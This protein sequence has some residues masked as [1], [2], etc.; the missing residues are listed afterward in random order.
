MTKIKQ[1]RLVLLGGI[2]L[3][4]FCLNFLMV[5]IANADFKWFITSPKTKTVEDL[6][7]KIIDFI[8]TLSS[9]LGGVVVL[10][11]VIAGIRYVMAKG[12]EE[13]QAAKGALF[14]ALI[15]LF[16]I[17]TAWGIFYITVNIVRVLFGATAIK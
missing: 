5:G 15:G 14:N 11:I 1:N 12:P 9:V 13:A 16:I 3:L 7:D 10:F 8:N 2:I 6:A 4:F 17:A